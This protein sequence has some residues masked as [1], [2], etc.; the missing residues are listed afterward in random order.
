MSPA[1]KLEYP[2]RVFKV[3]FGNDQEDAKLV[4]TPDDVARLLRITPVT[5]RRI[6][7]GCDLKLSD[8]FKIANRLGLT[9]EDLWSLR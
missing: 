9:I 4:I 8:A 5:A 1:K 7:E 6:V 2:P 3:K